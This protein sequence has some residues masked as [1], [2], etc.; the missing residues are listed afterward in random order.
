MG[1]FMDAITEIVNKVGKVAKKL[2]QSIR[3]F[4]ENIRDKKSKKVLEVRYFK[5]RLDDLA[6]ARA[7]ATTS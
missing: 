1:I 7:W 3:E 5:R 2:R 4:K 6:R